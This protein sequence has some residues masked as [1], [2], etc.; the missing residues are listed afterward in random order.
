MVAA[1]KHHKHNESQA[2]TGW[3]LLFRVA[4]FED[5]VCAPVAVRPAA[6]AFIAAGGM[7]IAGEAL[8]AHPRC[9]YPSRVT[10]R[11]VSLAVCVLDAYPAERA[12]FVAAGGLH[13]LILATPYA[14]RRPDVMEWL[15]RLFVLCGGAF[16]CAAAGA[17]WK[18]GR[19][20]GTRY[21]GESVIALLEAATTLLTTR[22]SG[23]RSDGSS[24][25]GGSAPA[26]VGEEGGGGNGAAPAAT[27]VVSALGHRMVPVASLRHRLRATVACLGIS[28]NKRALYQCAGCLVTGYC[29]TACQTADWK[30]GQK[31]GVEVFGHKLECPVLQ[32]VGAG[33]G[34]GAPAAVPPP[35]PSE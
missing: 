22:G 30:G 8:L 13:G 6:E 17:S 5:D 10:E 16:A 25:N 18:Y 7:A 23:G 2:S 33:A 4:T 31:A 3:K 19:C 15:G 11:V 21:P 35:P 28:C 34:A 12:T 27:P 32:F 24:S 9:D 29:G 20:D 14:V 26:G 1:L